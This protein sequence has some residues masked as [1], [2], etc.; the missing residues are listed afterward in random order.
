MKRQK[1]SGRFTK[2]SIVAFITLMGVVFGLCQVVTASDDFPRGAVTVIVPFRPG[3]GTDIETRNIL[4][5]VQKHL[6][7]SVVAKSM[8][9]AATTIGTAAAARA[10]PDGYTIICLPQPAGIL[11]QEFHGTGT[12][13]QN[14]EAI[15][16]WFEGPMD[17]AVRM[18]SP[19]KSFEA[20]VSV[21]QKRPLKASLAGI[22]SIDHLHT[23]LLKKY[24]GVKSTTIPYG[25]GGPATAAVIKGEVEWHVG[26]STTSVR[27][28]RNKQLRVLAILGPEPIEALSGVR[29]IYDIGFKSY[30][31]VSFVRGVLAPPGTP[32]SV[33]KKLETAFRKAVDD[34]GFREIM[35]KQGRPVKAFSREKMNAAVQNGYALA[36]QYIPFMKE[37]A[38]KK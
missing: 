19:Y 4:P 9:G 2:W 24:V 30:P 17:V 16:G 25:G 1:E 20:L 8:P 33:V 27:F 10:K 11:A 32:P 29:T 26:L 37:T 35:K 28:V 6:G 18:D 36:K 34:P 5:F 23:L 21:A 13:I 12:G 7:V 22:G 14:F 38:K 31:N 3:G 15:Y